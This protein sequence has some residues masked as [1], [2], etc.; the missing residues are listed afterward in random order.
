M[1]DFV[2]RERG[3]RNFQ[4]AG[5]V[6]AEGRMEETLQ[7]ERKAHQEREQHLLAQIQV[8]QQDMQVFYTYLSA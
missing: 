2:V 6:E 7:R 1:H 4:G 5:A 8:Y 3:N